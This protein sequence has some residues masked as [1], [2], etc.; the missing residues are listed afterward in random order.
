[1]ETIV[2]PNYAG[3]FSAWGLLEQDV[4][5]TAALTIVADLDAGGIERAEE[6]LDGLFEVLEARLEQRLAGS[7]R[8]EAEFDCRYP[9]QEYTLTVSVAFEDGR[10]TEGPEEIGSRFAEAYERNYGHSFE[11]GPEIESVRAIERT[12]LP[13]PSDRPAV[14]A[15]NGAAP[16]QS[17]ARAYSFVRDEWCEFA[18]ID[19][20]SLSPGDTFA[21]PAIV[22]EATA[23][24]YLDANLSVEVHA[25]GTLVA[26]RT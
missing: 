2:I 8:R 22:Q 1:M 9:G 12:V 15:A 16:E 25:S 24:S 7:V 4:V 3:N 11:L 10:I 6:S 21:G 18:V 23:T 19:R 13:R 5:R 14:G 20:D 26:T 17:S